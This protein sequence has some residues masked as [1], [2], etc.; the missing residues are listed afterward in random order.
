MALGGC[1]LSGGVRGTMQ[2][3]SEPPGLSLQRDGSESS[4]L[5]PSHHPGLFLALLYG[6]RS[7]TCPHHYKMMTEEKSEFKPELEEHHPLFYDREN[8]SR[9]G[10]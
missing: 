7:E 4:V 3:Q 2:P 9:E 10:E 8:R 6:L 5:S 1:G